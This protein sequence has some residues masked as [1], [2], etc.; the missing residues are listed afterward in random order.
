MKLRGAWSHEAQALSAVHARAFDHAWSA[1]D[2]VALIDGPGGF[3]LLVE[4]GAP[5][6]GVLGFILCRAIAGEAE[7]LTLAVDLPA[8]RRGLARA[9]V[10]AAAGA[11]QMAG[12]DV[13][14]L[15]VA[16]DNLPAIGLDEAAGFARTGLR[17]AYYDRGAAPAADALVMR[18]DL[19][20]K[21]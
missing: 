11:A 5:A 18:R 14:F 1:P 20:R 17:K 3:A 12:A 7:I 4:Q 16:H 9:L 8:R 10:E 21:A 19:G 6:E 2:I 15:A 13:M